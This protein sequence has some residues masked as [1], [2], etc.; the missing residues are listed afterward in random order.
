MTEL[1]QHQIEYYRARAPEY[2]EWF[3]RLGR[4]DRGEAH[5]RQWQREAQ[6][7]REQLL[8]CSGFGEILELAPGTG[9]WTE[10][11]IR[12]GE[13]VTA[14]DASPEMIA[15]NRAKL[16]SER[17]DYQLVD[18]FAWQPRQQ[19]DMVFFGF[20]LSH[21]PADK[22]SS[23]LDKVCAALKP[24]GRLFIVD[25]L[26]PEPSNPRTLI[27][28]QAGERQGRMLKD[29]RRYQIVKIYYD[30]AELSETLRRHG[31]AI[32]VKGT[33]NFFLYADGEREG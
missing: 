1:L 18:L 13:K 17:V 16:Q 14:L 15:I 19:Y 27:T 20:W 32:T 9:I 7:V 31:F 8:S 6:Q 5:T 12:I 4:Y 28:K 24:G 11:L 23:F 10:Q 3:Y 33:A 25:S 2:D 29:G 22:L 30:L 21:V 26:Q